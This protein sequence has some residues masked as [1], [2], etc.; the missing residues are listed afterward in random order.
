[1]YQV[2]KYE[3]KAGICDVRIPKNAKLLHVATQRNQTFIWAQVS[4]A[5]NMEVR[6]FYCIHTGQEF[7]DVEGYNLEY[8]GT[9][10]TNG[11]EYV[12]HVYECVSILPY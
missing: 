10:I 12:L 5:F 9:S 1:M 2:F 3:L 4:T 11:G 8:I 7:T 6:Q